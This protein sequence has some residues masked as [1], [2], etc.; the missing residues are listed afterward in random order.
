MRKTRMLFMTALCVLLASSPVL[1]Q[2]KNPGREDSPMEEE[3]DMMLFAGAREKG[4]KFD[5][6]PPRSPIGDMRW[7]EN[8]AVMEKLKLSDSQLEKIH[9]LRVKTEKEMIKNG[10][11]MSEKMIDL[12]ELMDDEKLNEGKI[13]ELID[14]ISRVQTL[15]FTA[16]MNTRLDIARILTAEQRKEL[17]DHLK[18]RGLKNYK[19]K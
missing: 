5:G 4:G 6:P 17:R 19:K 7:L 2:E 13:R 14:E 3:S 8:K 1:A 11:L 9:A 12:N 15:L 16:R 10:A 18:F